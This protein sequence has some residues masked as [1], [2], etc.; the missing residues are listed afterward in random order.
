MIR[1]WEETPRDTSPVYPDDFE[2]DWE[3]DDDWEDEDEQRGP[4]DVCINCFEP[5]AMDSCQQCGAPLCGMCAELGAGFCHDHPDKD[6]RPDGYPDQRSIFARIGEWIHWK[7][8]EWKF[9]RWF[10][11]NAA[12]EELPDEEFPF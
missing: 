11:K 1:T 9:D 4:D 3:D 8:A 10:A 5:G 2:D 7:I 6:Y 12:S